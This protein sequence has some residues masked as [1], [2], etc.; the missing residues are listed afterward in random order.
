MVVGVEEYG[1]KDCCVWMWCVGENVGD[2]LCEIDDDCDELGDFGV[3]RMVGCNLFGYDY[4][5]VIDD[6]CLGDWC[7]WGG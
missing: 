4:L 3:F 6:E 2:D 5:D 7:D 1:G